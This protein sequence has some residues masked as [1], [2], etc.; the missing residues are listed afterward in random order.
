MARSSRRPP[1]SASAFLADRDA[2]ALADHLIRPV[3]E[4]VGQ[5]WLVGAWDI[6]QERQATQIISGTLT[7]LIRSTW[8]T[9]RVNR[10]LALGGA[11]EGDLYNL[12]TILG[13]LVL[14]VEGWDVKN[15]GT[16]LP[17]RSMASAIREYRPRLVFLSASYLQDR[18]QF[19]QDYAYFYEAASQV[20]A[21]IILGGRAFDAD[22]RSRL[23]YASFG[24]R[25]AHLGEFARRLLP[26]AETTLGPAISSNQPGQTDIST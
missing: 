24:E 15:L 8:R 13:E 12:P 18:S 4:R 22:L 11:P 20:G 10:P 25:M 14:R 2:V 6:Y 26:A 16:H 19:L 1:S 23:V 21:A 7:E 3:M 9:D 17:I 5:L